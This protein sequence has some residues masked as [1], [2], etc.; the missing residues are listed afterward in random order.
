[1]RNLKMNAQHCVSWWSESKPY[2]IPNQNQSITLPVLYRTLWFPPVS[3]IHQHV[4]LKWNV[5]HLY[6]KIAHVVRV[7][8]ELMLFLIVIIESWDHTVKSMSPTKKERRNN[9][10]R[11]FKLKYHRGAGH[12]LVRSPPDRNRDKQR[13]DGPL[14][15]CPDLTL[16]LPY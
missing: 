15:S 2:T 14:G 1:M 16:T 11:G 12:M 4:N 3:Q 9:S 5:K 8:K 7:G 10:D 13:P 6:F